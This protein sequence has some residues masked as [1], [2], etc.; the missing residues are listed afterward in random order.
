MKTGRW[1]LLFGNLIP[2]EKVKQGSALYLSLEGKP[3]QT[4]LAEVGPSLIN[5]EQGVA[6]IFKALDRYYKKDE[7]K[8]A[9]FAF[10]DFIKYRR[11][12]DMSLN[13]FLIEFNLKYHRLENFNM[14]LPDGVFRQDE[15]DNRKGW[16]WFIK[17]Y[18]F[19]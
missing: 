18:Y 9:Y 3:R 6:N 16:Y 17:C 12:S 10:D 8:T 7:S 2:V 14:K 11:A 4:V 19:Q 13:D 1:R 15:G 5:C